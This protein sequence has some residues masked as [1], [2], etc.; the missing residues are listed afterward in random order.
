MYG[1]INGWMP[2]L[3][4]RSVLSVICTPMFSRSDSVLSKNIIQYV[5]LNDDKFGSKNTGHSRFFKA[6][7]CLRETLFLK[8]SRSSGFIRGI[9]ENLIH[10]IAK[11]GF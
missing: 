11:L 4:E 6:S 2:Y 7:A 10:A 1:G 3:V 8:S 9:Y 5:V